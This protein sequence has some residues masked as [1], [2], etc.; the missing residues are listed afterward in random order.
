MKY[1]Q[2][3]KLL[4]I[5]YFFN[6]EHPYSQTLFLLHY[7][8]PLKDRVNFWKFSIILLYFLH[9]NFCFKFVMWR[10]LPFFIVLIHVTFSQMLFAIQD[11]EDDHFFVGYARISVQCAT[12]L[13]H[14]V[15][16]SLR[17]RERER[18]KSSGF[19]NN[20]CKDGQLWTIFIFFSLS[21]EN[22]FSKMTL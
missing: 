2:K 6:T 4:F 13:V 5:F 22:Y 7:V 18:G 9:N 21:M 8:A 14:H 17:E 1:D 11:D 10:I 15:C 12:R 3:N 19:S 16:K 20:C